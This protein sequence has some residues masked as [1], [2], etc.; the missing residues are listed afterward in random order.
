MKVEEVFVIPDYP[1]AWWR[2]PEVKVG[3]LVQLEDA[4]GRGRK[5]N[6]RVYRVKAVWDEGVEVEEHN[7]EQSHQ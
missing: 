6:Y 7:T 2:R 4:F 1:H 5:G 3:R